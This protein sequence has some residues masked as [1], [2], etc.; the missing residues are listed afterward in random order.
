LALTEQY[1]WSDLPAR[2]AATGGLTMAGRIPLIQ[3]LTWQSSV[4]IM[5]S[6]AVHQAQRLATRNDRPLVFNA[7]FPF[8][9][10]ASPVFELT[11]ISQVK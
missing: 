9:S 2:D 8:D 7:W 1:S 11:Y 5:V 3:R 4:L 6:H 10:A